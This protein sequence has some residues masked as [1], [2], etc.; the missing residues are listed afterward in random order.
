M[1]EEAL[2]K[3]K[4]RFDILPESI[5]EMIMS[6]GYQEDLIEISKKYNLNVEQMGKLELETTMTMMGLTP[7]ADFQ[8][9]LTR[10]LGVDM[11]IGAQIVADINTQIFA[12]I[13]D[14][15]KIMNTPREEE[16]PTPGAPSPQILEAAG[17]PAKP[18]FEPKVI[19]PPAPTSIPAR[20]LSGSFQMPSAQ[21]DHTTPPLTPEKPDPY[22]EPLE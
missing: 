13:R 22:R 12:K 11:V 21:T 9:E 19:Q 3:I 10:E 4:G 5:K 14:L 20:K 17:I 15:L 6:S 7:T 1:D 16:P 8:R 18:E 2:K